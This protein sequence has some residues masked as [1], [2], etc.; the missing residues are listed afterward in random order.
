MHDESENKSDA[1]GDLVN[2]IARVMA[3]MC[4]YWNDPL[5]SPRERG[6]CAA[7][8]RV[9]DVRDPARPLPGSGRGALPCNTPE[10]CTCPRRRHMSAA[11]A[12]MAA[13]DIVAA[14]R[15]GSDDKSKE[16]PR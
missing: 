4:E 10:A 1:G 5:P 12:R 7:G 15:R 6:V 13:V 8:V 3:Q 11:T 14:L 2:E 9:D 16:E